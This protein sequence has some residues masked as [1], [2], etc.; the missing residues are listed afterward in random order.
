M[1]TSYEKRDWIPVPNHWPKRH[2]ACN[3]PCDFIRGHCAC[4]A[5]HKLEEEWVKI[6]MV[7][8]GFYDFIVGYSMPDFIFNKEK[9]NGK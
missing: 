8:Y 2:N 9:D 5:A 7:K 4:G 1:K 6:G 3:Q